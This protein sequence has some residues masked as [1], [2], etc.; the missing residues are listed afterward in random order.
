M[1]GG[2]V[3]GRLMGSMGCARNGEEGGGRGGVAA[4]WGRTVG[5]G[6]A[7]DVLGMQ[8]ELL[9][10]GGGEGGV[11]AEGEDAAGQVER[12]RGEREEVRGGGGR[13]E[14]GGGA[15]EE[16]R[17]LKHA[18]FHG[19]LENE[20]QIACLGDELVPPAEGG[21]RPRNELESAGAR[22]DPLPIIRAFK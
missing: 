13:I 17:V 15:V 18:E 10:L 1:G 16:V 5:E 7:E 2:G 4:V 20:V 14:L 21:Q 11:L 22:I 8:A 12:R 3:G 6:E 19:V 9:G